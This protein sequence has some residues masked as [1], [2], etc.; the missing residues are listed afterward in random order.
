MSTVLGI[1]R[2]NSCL[3]MF[4]AHRSIEKI[5]MIAK[6]KNPRKAEGIAINSNMNETGA[7]TG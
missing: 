4:K 2:G 5:Q 6:K 7:S 1:P 3:P